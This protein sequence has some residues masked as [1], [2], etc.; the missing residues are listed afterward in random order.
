M[1]TTC[2]NKFSPMWMWAL[3]QCGTVS[4]LVPLFPQDQLRCSAVLLE[5]G[6]VAPGMLG[7]GSRH[8]QGLVH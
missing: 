4:D 6:A 7:L 8:S 2:S 5:P 3:A 1:T